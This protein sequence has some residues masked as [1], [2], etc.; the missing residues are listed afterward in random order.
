MGSLQMVAAAAAAVEIFLIFTA[1]RF[2]LETKQHS[3]HIV[4]GSFLEVTAT[5]S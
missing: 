1:S 2:A 5:G 3:I 4:L